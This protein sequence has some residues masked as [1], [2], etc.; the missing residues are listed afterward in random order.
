[1][2]H[3]IT[4]SGELMRSQ[5]NIFYKACLILTARKSQHLVL[6]LIKATYKNLDPTGKCYCKINYSKLILIGTYNKA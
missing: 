3:I 2:H 6:F 4:I 1:M 5:K